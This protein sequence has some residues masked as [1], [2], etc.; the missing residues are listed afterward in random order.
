MKPYQV[1]IYDEEIDFAFSLMN[2]MNGLKEFSCM[3]IAFTDMEKVREYCSK[4]NKVDLLLLNQNATW[5]PITEDAKRIPILWLNQGQDLVHKNSVYKYQS[6]ENLLQAIIQQ[7]GNPT[8]QSE[9]YE[10]DT[11]TVYGVYSPIGRCG[12]TN[13][14]RAICRYQQGSSL[15]IG[16][17]TYQ[18]FEEDGF[19]SQEFLYKMKVHSESIKELLERL[20]KD[21]YGVSM[22]PSAICYLDYRELVFEDIKWLLEQLREMKSYPT[23]VFDIGT[24]SLFDFRIFSLFD[25]NFILTLKEAK[26]KEKH[27]LTFMNQSFQTIYQNMQLL[28]VPNAS[29]DSLKMEEYVANLL[30]GEY[31]DEPNTGTSAG[32]TATESCRHLRFNDRD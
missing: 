2:Y 10:I 12:K 28:Q 21:E 16:F 6:A 32:T 11:C 23:V 24:G 14:A 20:Q 30:R 26:A 3:G 4:D 22:I 29:Y 15:Y 27:F 19:M 31:Y 8:K 13:L 5:E 18:S 1:V 7:V 25:H 9:R 17:E